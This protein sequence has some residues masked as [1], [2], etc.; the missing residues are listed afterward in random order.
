MGFHFHFF[1]YGSRNLVKDT[2]ASEVLK[3]TILGW[4]GQEHCLGYLYI[5]HVNAC[6]DTQF[7][8][9]GWICYKPNSFFVPCPTK[10]VFYHWRY[11]KCYFNSNILIYVFVLRKKI[12]KDKSQM[13]KHKYFCFAKHFRRLHFMVNSSF[14]RIP[15][16]FRWCCDV[17]NVTYFQ[18]FYCICVC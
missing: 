16:W 10:N 13:P 9:Y 8:F 2:N 14:K 7:N 3:K 11:T 12:K 5:L 18:F 6:F 1:L 17:H 4:K 15:P